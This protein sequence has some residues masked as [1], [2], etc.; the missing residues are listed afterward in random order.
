[1]TRDVADYW[2]VVVCSCV[3]TVCCLLSMRVVYCCLLLLGVVT[4]CWLLFR[5]AVD[6]CWV[7]LTDTHCFFFLVVVYYCLLLLAVIWVTFDCCGLFLFVVCC[8]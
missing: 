3:I 6:G 5:V 7:L 2:L 8:W 1:M 4:C